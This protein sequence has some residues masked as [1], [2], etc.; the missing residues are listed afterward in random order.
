MKWA[1]EGAIEIAEGPPLA[2]PPMTVAKGD[3][4]RGARLPEALTDAIRETVGEGGNVVVHVPRRSYASSLSCAACGESLVCPAC[5]AASL[6]YQKQAETLV[7]G[8]CK[9]VFPYDERCRGAA[10]PFIRFYEVGAEYLEAHLK[11]AFPASPVTRVTGEAP[12]PADITSSKATA[13]SSSGRAR[14][15]SSTDLR[16][17]SLSSMG[18]R[19]T[20]GS[21][22]TGPGSACSSSFRTC[23]TR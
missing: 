18:G 20:S 22:A 9:S 8:S 21:A 11:E 5:G 2:A 7:C 13:A 4:D 3:H 17:G 23:G 1:S 16:R 6:A 14:S 12:W 19:A 10:G 15:R